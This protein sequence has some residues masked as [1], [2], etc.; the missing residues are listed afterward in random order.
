M[1]TWRRKVGASKLGRL[2]VEAILKRYEVE[3][4]D[5]EINVSEL[6]PNAL[7]VLFRAGFAPVENEKP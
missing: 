7:L 2:D 3:V 5:D 4:V 1:K 6:D